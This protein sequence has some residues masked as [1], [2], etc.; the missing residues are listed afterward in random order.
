MTGIY[1]VLRT[2]LFYLRQNLTVALGV[3]ISTAVLCGGLIIGDSVTHSLKAGTLLRLGN[4]QVAVMGNE[5]IF[6]ARLA[7]NLQD[8]LGSDCTPVLQLA[9]SASSDGGRLRISRLQVNGVDGRFDRAAGTQS[10]YETLAGNEVII[11]ENLAAR[12]ELK[13]GDFFVLRVQKASVFPMNTPFVS[14]ENTTV[15]MRVKVKS[16]A[17]ASELGRF[18]IRISQTAPYNV[19]I[20]LDQLNRE[21]DLEGRA[22]LVL[23]SGEDARGTDASATDIQR[24]AMKQSWI[25]EDASAGDI[26][27]DALK[28][29]WAPEDAGLRIDRL[30]GTD[31]IELS[32]ERVFIEPVIAG[33]F[34]ETNLEKQYILTYFVNSIRHGER[35]T[36]YSFVSTLDGLDWGM[37][38]INEWLAA[39][40]GI[41][42]GDTVDMD[43]FIP[44]PLRR[45]EEH[46]VKMTVEGVL[47][48][49]NRFTD[50]NLVPDLPGLSDAGHCRDWEAGIPIDLEKIRDKDED[51]WNR[52][53]GT[54]KAFI[55]LEEAEELW[56]NRFGDYTAIRFSGELANEQKISEILRDNLDPAEL[57]I[58]AEWVRENGLEAAAGG[59][60]F[61][62]LFIS[63]SFFVLVS[64]LILTIL[65][66]RLNLHIRISQAGTLASMGYPEK[67]IGRIYLAEG[68]LTALAGG[69]PGIFLAILL[70]RG[71][72]QM[73]DTLWY[74]IVRTS[75]LQISIKPLTLATGYFISVLVS[76]LGIYILLVR[77]LRRSPVQVQK[78]PWK[79][80]PLRAP[81]LSR[82]TAPAILSTGLVLLGLHI[83][84]LDPSQT[85]P[86]LVAGGLILISLILYQDLFFI[87]LAGTDRQDISFRG[88][89]LKNAG[90][91][92][93][94]RFAI[95]VL[96]ALGT[97]SVV[98]TGANRRDSMTDYNQKSSGT[99]GFD[100]YAE[101]TVPILY[102]LNNQEAS[103]EAGIEGDYLFVQF[104]KSDGDDASC[105][106][107]NRILSPVLLGVEPSDL[108]ERFRFVT[109]TNDLDAERPWS[110][111]ESTLPGGVVPAI[112]DQTVIQWGLGKKMGDTL[113]YR[114]ERGDSL[115]I[116]LIGGIA[117]S[118][119]QGNLLI[120]DSNFL[121]HYPS[122]SGASVYLVESATGGET[123]PEIDLNRALRDNGWYMKRAPERLAEFD[124]VQNTYLSI[125]SLLGVLALLLGTVGLGI[126]LVRNIMERRKEIALMQSMGYS[127]KL[128]FS[129]LSIEYFLLISIGILCGFF[130]GM[131]STLPQLVSVGFSKASESL[132]MIMLIL[133]VNSVLWIGLFVWISIIKKY[134]SLLALE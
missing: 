51:Y 98:L 22:N 48:M 8:Q 44:G 59:V 21:M 61:S 78:S 102:D 64:A 129:V 58:S 6:T 80:A 86:F 4:T 37:I 66:F 81:V 90:M 72:F 95:I 33:L 36:P 47:P 55:S 5:R 27:Q 13:E 121:L 88:M 112:A 91:A 23:V 16:L 42:A 100:Y 52:Y 130:T 2:F 116:K 111:L 131:I 3:A 134:E 67:L 92:R 56:Q 127:R 46:S 84:E 40:L 57:G 45:L 24:E 12:L 85:M 68:A 109:G 125:F 26:L 62:Q 10:V 99:G 53:R 49:E 79:S 19:F 70:T 28:R 38:R 89:V 73:L 119:L 15:S 110:S 63:L 82:I 75:V 104:R 133:L 123:D 114:N 115:K 1:F 25:P 20:N 105:L 117:P 41:Q 93:Q 96:F 9:G 34:K 122:V 18:N 11:S 39:D 132:L 83:P 128:V 50:E 74:D 76:W 31:M 124:S 94:R 106:N 77:R 69:I 126:V 43:Y 60:D 108:A 97:Y 120:S 103:R 87:R 29:S 14:D 118:V 32:T 101:S 35:E 54:P 17:G 30:Q 107:L 7:E 113:F 65:L 71:V